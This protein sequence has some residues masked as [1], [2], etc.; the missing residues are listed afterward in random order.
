MSDDTPQNNML[1]VSDDEQEQE[2]EQEQTQEQTQ[3]HV[4]TYN[5]WSISPEYAVY[6][7]VTFNFLWTVTKSITGFTYTVGKGVWKTLQPDTYY[8]FEG[9]DAAYKATDYS[10]SG[11]GIPAVEWVYDSKKKTFVSPMGS[12]LS[13]HLP[14]LSAEIKHANLT[15][16]DI[17]EF[18]ESIRYFHDVGM[19]S[20]TTV[21]TVPSAEHVLSAW[22][23]ESGIVLDKSGSLV[24]SVINENGEGQEIPLYQRVQ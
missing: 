7:L 6:A 4:V 24:L 8:F 21:T 1:P 15:L 13:H 2:Q 22:S 17:T 12:P 20:A 3:G 11:P 9:Y 19:P 5:Q 14:W 23:L 18:V 10:K 16:Y